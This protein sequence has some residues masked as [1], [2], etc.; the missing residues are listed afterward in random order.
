MYTIVV[1]DDEEELRRA[2]IRRVNWEEIGFQ[3][4]GEAE[5]GIEA[6][7]LVEKMEPDLLLT[8][9]KMPFITGIELARQVREIR[10]STHIA[11][12]SGF[13][14][15]TYAQQAIQYNIISYMLKPISMADLTKELTVIK[16]K[17]DQIFREFDSKQKE[18]TD[19]SE[20]LIPLLLD[21]FQGSFSEERE[22][23]LLNRAVDC[24]LLKEASRIFHYAVMTVSV[25]DEFGHNETTQAHVHSVNTILKKYMKYASFYAEGRVVSLLLATPSAFEKYLHIAVGEVVQSTQRIMKRQC[26][27]GISR[28]TENLSYCHESYKEAV[29]ACSYDRKNHSGVHYI[30]DEER[31]EMIDTDSILNSVKEVEN[32]IRGGSDQELQAYLIW[33]F[34]DMKKQKTSRAAV[35]FLLVQLLASVCRIIF[36]VSEGEDTQEMQDYILMQQ[37]SFFTGSLEETEEKFISFCIRVREMISSQRKKSSIVLC[38]KV[39]QM[40]ENEYANQD[41]SLNYVSGRISVSPNYL[42]T[43]IKR[44]TGKTFVDLLTQ[45]RMEAAKDM[46]LCSSMKIREI[47][48]KCGYN[49]QHYFSY[50]FKK[51]EGV[52]P[53]A[54]R[55][56]NN[57]DAES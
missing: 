29:S 8:D 16:E 11:F 23:L 26:S 42:S 2:I 33:M 36:A 3:V 1:A 34:A 4:V 50:C 20:F 9:I 12:L 49:D 38:D 47:S 10:P 27:I 21:E 52:S 6:L 44:H 13:D 37:M 57:G 5:N 15:F 7:E 40:I 45:K 31:A 25:F 35:N 48:E 54:L 56:K 46:L 53:G 43:L 41:M 30:A 14:D 22:L 55:S 51:Y 18:Q 32:L 24:G 19:L 17:M 28:I 39:M